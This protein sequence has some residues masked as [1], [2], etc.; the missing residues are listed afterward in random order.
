MPLPQHKYLRAEKEKQLKSLTFKYSYLSE[1]FEII[2]QQQSTQ[3]EVLELAGNL[4]FSWITFIH[5]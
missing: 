3:N 2:K 5:Y 1:I 4:T